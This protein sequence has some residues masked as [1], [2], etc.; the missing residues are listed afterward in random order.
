[1]GNF[2]RST[3]ITKAPA[4]QFMGY[5]RQHQTVYRFSIHNI[6]N[7]LTRS[8]LLIYI[9]NKVARIKNHVVLFLLFCLTMIFARQCLKR[10]TAN[11]WVRLTC[12]EVMLV[13]FDGDDEV[14]RNAAK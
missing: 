14:P 5:H 10:S 3:V 9:Q 4:G 2:H 1:M 12:M 13:Q 11:L 6:D 7:S 8:G